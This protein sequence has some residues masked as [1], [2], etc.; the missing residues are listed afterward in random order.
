LRRTSL[1]L[2]ARPT[3]EDWHFVPRSRIVESMTR[4]W[5]ITGASSGFGHELARQA[6]EQGDRV[7]GTVRR[8]DGAQD[9]LESH[10][11]SFHRERL[12]LSD[13]E[14]IRPVIDAAVGWLGGLDVVVNNAG[15]GLFGA[16]EELTDEQID[17]EIAT[18]LRGSIQVA[19][20]SLRFLRESGG[21]RILQLSSVAGQSAN[22]GASLYHATK[23]GGCLREAATRPRATRRGWLRR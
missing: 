1:A 8:P 14:R 13:T 23:W 18:N 4:N 15:Y 10:P 20:A 6:L 9:L 12:D 16:A 5:I 3:P 2:L 19:R 17:H 7:V 22:P 11:D 21:G